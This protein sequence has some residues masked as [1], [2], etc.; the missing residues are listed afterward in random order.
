M[1]ISEFYL[2]GNGG[3]K[4][5]AGVMDMDTGMRKT[6][7]FTPPTGAVGL[8]F[9]GPGLGERYVGD[10]SQFADT[11]AV[12]PGNATIEVSY[13]YELTL[14]PNLLIDHVMDTPIASVV[15]IV[16]GGELGLQG[17]ELQ[18]AGNMDTQ[19]GPALSYT[20][21]PLAAQEKLSFT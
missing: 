19:M 3:D 5:F 8:T 16:S 11:R 4:T 9:E 6:V 18:F 12:P 10:V 1:Q 2:I 15:I 14:E 21:G 13:S 20:A 17:T 7:Q